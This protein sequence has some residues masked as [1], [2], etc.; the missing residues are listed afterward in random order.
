M[1]K[2]WQIILQNKA[3]S[4]TEKTLKA[5]TNSLDYA[6]C[7]ENL[8]YYSG[9]VQ[10]DQG[11]QETRLRKEFEILKVTGDEVMVMAAG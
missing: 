9:S 10:I 11:G 2:Q 8:T 6:I 5:K 3:K 7:Y 4:T 1:E